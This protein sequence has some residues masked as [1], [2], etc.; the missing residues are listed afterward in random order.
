MVFLWQ[1]A[2]AMLGFVSRALPVVMFLGVLVVPSPAHAAATAAGAQPVFPLRASKNGRYLTDAKG[3]PFFI[4]ADT[5]WGAP[6]LTK[7]GL[8]EYLDRRKADG[9]TGILAQ[10][11]GRRPAKDRNGHEP[12]SPAE[13]ITRPN[14]AYWKNVDDFLEAAA[15]RALVVALAPLW[16]EW[17]GANKG[18]WRYTLDDKNAS[19]YGRFLGRRY[20]RFKNLMWILGGDANPIEITGAIDRL[21]QTLAREAR[22]QLIMVHNRTTYASAA[23]FDRASWLGVNMAYAYA[24]IGKHVAGEWC[25]VGK[26]RP[27]LLGESGYEHESNS[28]LFLRPGE[29]GGLPLQIRHQA[30]EAVLAGALAGHAYGHRDVYFFR[31]DWRKGMADEGARHMSHVK[32]LFGALPYWKLV[33]DV[34]HRLIPSV[35]TQA[36]TGTAFR[37]SPKITAATAEDRTFAIAYF[38]LR[39]TVSLV[40]EVLTGNVQGTWFDPTSGARQPAFESRAAAGTVSVTSPEKNRAGDA[41]WVL[42]V[43]SP[44][45]W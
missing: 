6:T 30:Y 3:A 44:V 2:A 19:V 23:F 42:I 13:D 41:D 11:F 8:S 22:H 39:Q 1:D 37:P 26:P 5:A 38:P 28:P 16:V 9:F 43:Q 31:G 18:G 10:T 29:Q 34:H 36:N 15:A 12:F 45:D 40:L 35:R 7:E 4:H 27:I 21:G 25:R 32:G 14:E 24:D 33:P 20:R 17:G